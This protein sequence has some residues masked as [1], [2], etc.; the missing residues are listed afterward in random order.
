MYRPLPAELCGVH[1]SSHKVDVVENVAWCAEPSKWTRL[2][3]PLDIF[4]LGIAG[5]NIEGLLFDIAFDVAKFETTSQAAED[6]DEVQ[7]FRRVNGSRLVKTKGMLRNLDMKYRV[8]I[9]AVISVPLRALT[10][11]FIKASSGFRG[12][13]VH[14]PDLCSLVDPARSPILAAI[15][16]V[17]GLLHWGDGRLRLVWGYRG[18][19]SLAAFAAE[20]MHLAGLLRRSLLALVAW[21]RQRH[22]KVFNGYP[23]KLIGRLADERVSTQACLEVVA[24]WR[25]KN[26][27]A[28]RPAYVESCALVS[29]WST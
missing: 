6:E 4:I 7:A 1:C 12:R 25:S 23:D 22:W 15:Q 16:H 5:S 14:E 17:S 2:G 27:A 3:R 11:I 28:F 29:R 20:N 26:R 18:H 9:L 8:L 24:D 19:P 13:E 21:I 10:M